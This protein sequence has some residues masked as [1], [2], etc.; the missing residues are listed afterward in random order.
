MRNAGIRKQSLKVG[1]VPVICVQN[2]N[3]R[4]FFDKRGDN[5]T[6][7]TGCATRD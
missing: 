4:A 7:N 2:M 3:V 5:C 1:N 6:P